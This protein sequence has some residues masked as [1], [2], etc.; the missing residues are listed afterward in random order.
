MSY[1]RATLWRLYNIGGADLALRYADIASESA[2]TTPPAGDLEVRSIQFYEGAEVYSGSSKPDFSVRFPKSR[3]RFVM[4]WVEFVHPWKYNTFK[5]KMQIRYFG[6]D[7]SMMSQIEDEIET[8]PQRPSFWYS[9]GR[10]WKEPGKWQ[11]GDYRVQLLINGMEKQSGT[12]TIF[13]DQPA[14]S[15]GSQGADLFALPWQKEGAKGLGIGDLVKP[16]IRNPSV[17]RFDP[18]AD[19][20]FALPSPKLPPKSSGSDGWLKWL[21][22]QSFAA[23]EQPR[24]D[25]TQPLDDVGKIKA[26]IAIDQRYRLAMFDTR[27]GRVCQETLGVIEAIAQDYQAL[28]SLG[29]P[30]PPFE[31]WSEQS[32]QQKIGDT[33]DLAA[34]AAGTLRDQEA[35][36]R[37]YE[38]A[39]KAY[40]AAG[41]NAKA[42]GCQ[43][44]LSRL[45]AIE[46]G[47]IDAEIRRLRGELA[48]A[49]RRSLAA[50]RAGIDLGMLYSNN[51]DDTEALELLQQAERDLKAVSSDPSGVDLAN[52][53]SSSVANL[54]Q[55]S[56]AGGP[57]AIEH[58]IEANN[59]YR[60]LYT[61]YARIY[62]TTDPGRAAEYRAKVTSR[63][64]RQNNDEFSKAMLQALHGGL[65]GKL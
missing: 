25:P 20:G 19:D 46:S 28:K 26:L 13:D 64:S 33:F 40:R 21:R 32:V 63:D 60:L 61:A 35:A 31:I 16:F 42:N 15:S 58:K 59:L 10:G 3:S 6:P 43:T 41:D 14:I 30:K 36:A 52:A 38:A 44:E 9:S 29:P 56:S 18:A 17:A 22:E 5:Y 50:A 49:P 48:K 51:G 37:Y 24:F 1:D 27:P 2:K 55:G 53:L 34:R 8:N 11:P 7:G 23:A 4:Y 12:F 65:L 54:L 62:E 39:T 47:D 57:S 45:Q